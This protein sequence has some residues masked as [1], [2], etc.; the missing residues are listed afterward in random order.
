MY[1][2]D[3]LGLVVKLLGEK[4]NSYVDLCRTWYKSSYSV[5]VLAA[6]NSLSARVGFRAAQPEKN[7]HKIQGSF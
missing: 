6:T 2:I 3:K 4:I 7:I 1:L 5:W